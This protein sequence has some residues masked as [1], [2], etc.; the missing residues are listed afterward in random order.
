MRLN[1]RLLFVSFLVFVIFN[2]S[3]FSSDETNKI[4]KPKNIIIMIGDG[5]GFNHLK[6]GSLYL[7]G[8]ADALAMYKFPVKYA[9]S[10]YPAKCGTYGEGGELKW[11]SSFSPYL[12]QQSPFNLL[13]D[14]TCSGAAAT[15]MATG[16]KTFNGAIGVDLNKTPIT[17]ISEIAKQNQ[18]SA[19]V[20]TSVPFCHATP[21]GFSAHYPDRDNYHEIAYQMIS[22]SKMDV[23]I[24][25]GNP[26]Y[27]HDGKPMSPN[28]KYSGDSLF[29]NSLVQ[30][31]DKINSAKGLLPLQDCNFDGKPDKWNL[32]QD[33]S[34]FI[35]LAKGKTPD[36][37]LGIAKAFETPRQKRGSEVGEDYK[38]ASA[39][40]HQLPFEVAF[41]N[42]LPNL[43]EMTFAALNVLD[44]NNN[45]FFLMIEGG[46]IDWAAHSN[47]KGRLIEEVADFN[48]AVED[49]VNWIE[50][51]SSWDET[52]LIVTA[53]HETGL[54]LG[55]KNPTGKSSSREIES[56]GKGK[57]PEMDF[58]ST[59]HSNSLVPFFAKGA[60]SNIFN[61]FADETDAYWGQYLNNTEIAQA[62]FILWNK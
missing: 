30:N 23:I 47:Q 46:A 21:A 49:I 41:N 55:P 38:K 7:T 62:V 42:N 10:T 60:G 43:S 58:N 16:K 50:S 20:V 40:G 9:M 32:I 3:L 17:N 54:L 22:E 39:K 18:K 24:G 1:K 11:A 44:N 15:A 5:M 56:N 6:S 25:Y 48:Q 51:N 53:D 29:W 8:S 36:R 27:D 33:K 45:G 61:I 59:N 12:N 57:L 35:S 14:F 13:A 26:N 31:S 52:L 37:L 2:S 34:E 28:Y 19:G 4:K